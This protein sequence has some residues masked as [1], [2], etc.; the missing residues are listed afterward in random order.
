MSVLIMLLRKMA[1]NRWL[2]AS[3]LAGM[4]CCIALTSSMPIYK[5][6]V[7]QYMLVQDMDR[8][9]AETGDHPGVISVDVAMRTDDPKL[10]AAIVD[11]FDSYWTSRIASGDRF[12]L[13]LNQILMETVRF[14]LT[15]ADPSRV[16]PD[17]KRSG[18]LAMRSGLEEKV[19]LVDGKLP[20]KQTVDGVYEVMV[21]DNALVELKMLL[22]QE[23]VIADPRVKRSDIRV[24]PVGVIAEQ[25]LSDVYW[26][27]AILGPERNTLFLAEEL[28]LQDFAEDA[29]ITIAKIGAL[30]A[31]DYSMFDLETAA[32]MIGLKSSMAADMMDRYNFSVSTSVWIPGSDAM[33]AYADREATLRNLLWSLN[34][35]LFILIGFYLY[36]VTGMLIERQKSEIAVLRSRGA[37]RL[38]IMGIYAAEFGL[39]ALLAYAIGPWIGAAFTRI[40]GSTSTFMSFVNRGALHVEMS[41]ES[42][43]YAGGAVAAAWVINLVPVFMATRASI[44]DQKRAKA[45]EGKR[46]A[47]QTYGLDLVLIGIAFYGYYL[48]HQRMSD[49][50]KLGLDGKSLSA[51]PLL[52]T[53]PTLFIL[54]TGLLLIRVYPMFVSLVYRLGRKRWAPQNYSTLLLVSRRNRIYHGLMLFLVLTVGTGIYNANTAR[55]ING[56][57]EDQI[58]YA[59]GSDIVLRQHWQNDAPPPQTPGPPQ[60]GA[61]AA[62]AVP[63]R[64]SYLEP[65]FE[66]VENLPGVESAAKVFTKEEAEAWLGTK[67]GKVTLK[68]IETD[69]FGMAAWMKDNLLPYHFYDYLNL[70]AP[71]AHAVLLS[72]T[73]ADYFGAKTGDV[74]DVGWEGIRPTRLIVYGVIDYFPSFNP[75]P[76]AARGNPNDPS[77]MLVVGHLDTI[78]NELAMEPYDVWMKLEPGADR[79]ALLDAMAER[80]IAIEKFEDTIGEIAESRMDPFRMAINGVMSLG[81]IVS[82]VIS[83]IGFMLFW[84]LSLQG[85]MLQ[86]GIYRAMG[87]SFR[88]L[89]GMLMIEQILTTGAGFLIGIATGLAAGRIF[90]PLFQLSFDPGKIVPPF[91]VITDQSD[92]IRMGISTSLMLAAA[93][94]ILAWILKRMN[95]YQAVKLGED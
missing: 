1:R 81:F 34:V 83:F 23:Y 46:A 75:N 72:K 52:Y 49:L 25:D 77:P 7:L 11:R 32:Y 63:S 95:I 88:Q 9:Y 65:P 85:R 21:T 12:D 89:L 53:V 24:K 38:H 68:G 48:F 58:W 90:V 84:L 10:Q 29:P 91:E 18:K 64:I 6:A 56:N 59:G 5:N 76:S 33:T 57:M 20:A 2:V 22:G 35:P 73:A 60:A 71:D 17:E 54:G 67:S 31:A 74:M 14:Q 27:R 26:S 78:Q 66:L 86:L 93:L 30:A 47:W 42:W 62:P 41:G 13:Q 3:L 28:F 92:I 19:R 55:T 44:V 36:M 70:M 16:N 8:S 94:L 37:S 43:L 45:R 40:L 80:G 50:V 69:A 51:D 79:Q 61:Q 4:L 87:I 39:L 82:L 15:P